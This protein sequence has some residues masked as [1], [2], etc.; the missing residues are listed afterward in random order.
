MAL[1]LICIDRIAGGG[2]KDGIFF[3]RPVWGGSSE[4]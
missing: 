4:G 1:L 2:V 3:M